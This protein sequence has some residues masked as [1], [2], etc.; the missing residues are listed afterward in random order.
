M[1]TGCSAAS[2]A[3][4]ACWWQTVGEVAVWAI[5]AAIGLSTARVGPTNVMHSTAYYQA[6]IIDCIGTGTRAK[7]II[8]QVSPTAQVAQESA[9]TRSIGNLETS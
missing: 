8:S 7:L 9:V 2:S 4:T 5:S 1:L 3:A 6:N